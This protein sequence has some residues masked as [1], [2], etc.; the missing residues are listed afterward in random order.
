MTGAQKS[1]PPQKKKKKKT[2]SAKN[3]WGKLRQCIANIDVDWD[4]IQNM[5]PMEHKLTTHKDVGLTLQ[6]HNM[7]SP[8]PHH[9]G[10]IVLPL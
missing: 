9:N 2:E 1:P 7:M 5:C 4:S 3:V 10:V 8:W 6:R